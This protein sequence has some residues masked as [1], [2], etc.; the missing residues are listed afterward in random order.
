MYKVVIRKT[1][2]YADGTT[3]L[4]ESHEEVNH[5][6]H[7]LNLAAKIA[8]NDVVESV[9]IEELRGRFKARAARTSNGTVHQT[10]QSAHHRVKRET[11]FHSG[12][13]SRVG[14]LLLLSLLSLGM[15]GYLAS[16][17]VRS[18]GS[19][20]N[21]ATSGTPVS[22]IDRRR[23]TPQHQRRGSQRMNSKAE[24]LKGRGRL[25]G[26]GIDA[27]VS[28]VL[29]VTTEIIDAGHLSDRTAEIDGL[30]NITGRV[31]FLS[32]TNPPLGEKLT[33]ILDD[34][35]KLWLFV[36]SDGSVIATGGFFK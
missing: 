36:Q 24:S 12:R 23:V 20:E 21:P 22:P 18:P 13:T 27:E 32:S 29:A 35:R 3:A 5:E 11:H 25:V 34:G 9:E 8:R 31:E 17:V 1:L 10:L 28:Y 14:K 15:L 30:K 2:R 7:A 19:R 16:H 4:E 26:T 6:R 33:L